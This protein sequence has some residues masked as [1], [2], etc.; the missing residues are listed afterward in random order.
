MT[1]SNCGATVSGERTV[2]QS[3]G[4]EVTQVA[5][6]TPDQSGERAAGQTRRHDR[7]TRQAAGGG[8]SR[9]DVLKYGG[10]GVAGLG[11]LAWIFSG[12]GPAALVK[13]FFR[14][15][16]NGNVKKAKQLTHEDTDWFT[17]GYFPSAADSDIAL[18]VDETTITENSG[19]E[20][21][22]EAVITESSTNSAESTTSVVDVALET[23]GGDWKIAGISDG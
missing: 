2:C 12:G 19:Q 10:G 13:T 15:L 18:S 7:Q 22:V 9:R 23:E 21:V 3:C 8:W 11:L 20:A 1:C 5:A 14:A 4:T 17:L 6:E 16:A